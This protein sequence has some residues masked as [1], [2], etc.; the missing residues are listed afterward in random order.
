MK[1]KAP[2]APLF[3]TAIRTNDRIYKSPVVPKKSAELISTRIT[4]I[5]GL[6]KRKQ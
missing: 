5:T 3:M 1:K 6:K 4:N 2:N